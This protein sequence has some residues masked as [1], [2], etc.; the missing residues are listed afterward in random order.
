MEWMK[1][2]YKLT[3]DTRCIDLAKTQALLSGTYWGVRRP[4]DVVARMIERSIPF[5]LLRDEGQIGFGRVVTDYA[6]F[7]WVADVVVDAPYRHQGLGKWMMRC[8][9]E[10]PD[11]RHTQMVLQ[12]RDAHTLYEQ[13]GF[14]RNTALMSTPVDGLG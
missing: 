10:H 2:E 9:V 4:P 3:D 8:I 13:Y 14:A 6:V 7:S 1:G 12:T 5:V 11:I